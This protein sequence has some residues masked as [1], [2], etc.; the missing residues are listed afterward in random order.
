MLTC[1]IVPPIRRVG[2]ASTRAGVLSYPDGPPPGYVYAFTPDEAY[3][4]M[5]KEP[6][7]AT[8]RTL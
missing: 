1:S 6:G 4:V 8:R 7:G 2:V 3:L 5:T